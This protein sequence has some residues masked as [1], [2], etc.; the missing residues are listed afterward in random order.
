M[1]YYHTNETKISD[2]SPAFINEMYEKGYVF[3]RIDRGIM[4]QTRSLRIDLSKFDLSSEN[5]RILKKT[6]A[7]ILKAEKIPF[8]NYDWSIGK[9][10]KDFYTEKFGDNVMSAQKIK[11]TL[12]DTSKSNFNT[13]LTYFTNA[14]NSNDTRNT[15]SGYTI[16]FKTPEIIHYSYPFYNLIDSP[17]DMGMGMMLRAII[18]AKEKGLKYIYLG[19]LQRPTDT[20]KLQFSGLEWF[21]G[22][23][24]NTDTE[25]VKEILGK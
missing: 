11:E 2:F 21:D 4:H 8:E 22:K 6:E 14:E 15:P 24:W 9:L 7:L 20:Y 13:V 16:C 17:K 12:T 5:R 18:F 23:I 25:L 10:A 1:N 3:T 19:S